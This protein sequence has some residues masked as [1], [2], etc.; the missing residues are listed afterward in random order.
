MVHLRVQSITCLE[1]QKNVIEIAN[2][3]IGNA[4][5]N[6]FK[7]GVKGANECKIWPIKK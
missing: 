3:R 1:L 5:E 4:L 2:E 6:A 7:N